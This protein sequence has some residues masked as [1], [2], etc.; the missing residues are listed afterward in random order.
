MKKVGFGQVFLGSGI[1]RPNTSFDRYDLLPLWWHV[2]LYQHTISYNCPNFQAGIFLGSCLILV[3]NELSNSSLSSSGFERYDLL[4]LWWCVCPRHSRLQ[5]LFLPSL[6]TCKLEKSSVKMFGG[7][8][9]VYSSLPVLLLTSISYEYVFK[10]I[11][12]RKFHKPS[13]D[14]TLHTS[15]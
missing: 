10:A 2:K 11:I 9:R 15:K 12:R 1:P 6:S 8:S 7:E 14:N 5:S 3:D 4:S 13:I